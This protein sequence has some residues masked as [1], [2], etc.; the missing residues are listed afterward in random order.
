MTASSLQTSPFL[1]LL[2]YMRPYRRDYLLGTLYSAL[3]KLM[4]IAPEIL[5]GV[6]VDTVV[7]KEGSLLGDMGFA[8]PKE[9]LAVLAVLTLI[10]WVLESV[11]QY[12]YSIKWRNLAQIVQHKLRTD[13]YDHVQRLDMETLENK[14][15]GT[16]LSIL[17][18]DV[19]QIERFLEDGVSQIIQI[20]VSTLVIGAI[21]FA[22]DPVIALVAVMPIPV[23]F[24]GTFAFQ[25]RL[26]GKFMTVREKAGLLAARL[27]NNLSSIMTIKSFSN[28][29]IEKS[30]IEEDSEAY[31]LANE[32]AILLSS[33]VTPVIRVAVLAGF[34]FTLVLGG[35]QTLDGTMEVGVFSVLVFL[36]QRLLWPLRELAELTVLY[37]RSMASTKRVLDL[38]H[39]PIHIRSGKKKMRAEDVKGHVAFKNITF[40]YD[41]HT[42]LQDI[43]IDIPAGKTIGLVG[44]SGSGKSTLMKLLM[45][46][47]EP[48]SGDVT[49]DGEGLASLDVSSLRRSIGFV[50]QDVFLF[51]GTILQNVAY[52]R[53]DAS[54]AD[55]IEACKKAEAHSFIETL[56]N[57]YNTIVGERGHRLSGGQR[58]RIAFA[59]A[60]LRNPPILVLDEAT[61]AV[62]NET[63][64]AIQKSLHIISQ[65]RTT[66][67]IAHRLSTVRHADCIFVMKHGEV[68][69][70]GS[71]EVL[72]K[73]NGT[74]ADLW[75][76]QIGEGL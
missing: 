14:R 30:K 37:Q 28:E 44:E 63:E 39:I 54:E 45:R 24:F 31:R 61:S 65:N 59:R 49:L 23:I 38:L 74:Y 75:K 1:R 66:I 11:T 42:A 2:S 52:G 56:E 41:G 20:I 50:S 12:L 4:D 15:T 68:T 62:D 60:I 58:Q 29:D 5:I 47:Y 7:R 6:A 64:R 46:F 33:L 34:L 40:Q 19:N 51:H 73:M 71:H 35:L 25:S 22:V 3:R 13:T 70:Q 53:P 21:F 26:A 16:L 48:T 8:A 57:G 55:I 32:S 72:L 67:I 17:N 76:L 27:S 43:S 9:Q 69:E 36:T 18:D 10:I